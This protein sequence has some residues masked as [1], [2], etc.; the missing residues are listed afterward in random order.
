M[1][2]NGP[3]AEPPATFLPEQSHKGQP[4]DLIRERGFQQ[5][6]IALDIQIAE[7]GDRPPVAGETQV[8]LPAASSQHMRASRAV[9]ASPYMHR[10][11]FAGFLVYPVFSV[12]LLAASA[13]AQTAPPAT[14][15]TT[16]DSTAAAP[17][18]TQQPDSSSSQNIPPAPTE[19]QRLELARQAQARVRSRRA[20]RVAAVVQD[21]YSHKYEVFGG[22]TFL[23]MRPGHDLQNFSENGF[24]AGFTDY[25]TNKLGVTVDGRGYYGTAYVGNL[26]NPYNIYEPAV[27]NYSISAGP[28]YRFYMRQKWSVSGMALVG[29]AHNLFYANSQSVPGTLVGLYPNQWRLSATVG[30]PIDYNLGPG[31]SLRLTP[32]YYYTN[33]GSESQNNKGVTAGINYR[34]GRR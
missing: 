9:E 33:F 25:F 34:F 13:R 23:R 7:I 1:H 20:Q 2:F 29:V 4:S 26:Q 14:P 18:Q 8:G 22:Y 10:S 31:L 11:K 21:T 27:S 16:P 12:V 15:T 32:N 17:A 19:A 24:D 3:A 30:V 5:Q 28:S 6:E